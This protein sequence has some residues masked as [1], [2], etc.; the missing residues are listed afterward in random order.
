[1]FH[2]HVQCIAIS[3][4][5]SVYSYINSMFSVQCVAFQQLML[6]TLSC[7]NS[8]YSVH[9]EAFQQPQSA[10][11]TLNYILHSTHVLSTVYCILCNFSSLNNV[12]YC[13]FGQHIQRFKSIGNVQCHYIVI[14]TAGTVFK[15]VYSVL[16]LPLQQHICSVSFL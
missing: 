3:T 6:C 13:H 9:H 10:A 16:Y 2:Q 8:I 15:R 12:L 5:C 14:S 7:L 4:A 1:M 11:C